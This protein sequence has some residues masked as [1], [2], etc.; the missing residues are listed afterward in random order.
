MIDDVIDSHFEEEE[1]RSNR[2]HDCLHNAPGSWRE[3]LIFM[4][5]LSLL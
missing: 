1:H 3:C 2:D 4:F 5:V